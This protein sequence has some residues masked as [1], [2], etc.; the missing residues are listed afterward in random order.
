MTDE[1]A[2]ARVPTTFEMVE[3]VL[4]LVSG[5]AVS[6]FMLPGLTLCLPALVVLAVVVLVPLV[7]A[8]AI[9]ALLAAVLTIPWLLVRYARSL[10][11]RRERPA[12]GRSPA[13][14]TGMQSA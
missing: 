11:S 6:A 13:V 10:R 14:G 3:D 5:V 2:E 1:P 8:V 7:A 9:A 12:L 4:G